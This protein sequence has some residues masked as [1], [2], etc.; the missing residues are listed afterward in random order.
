MADA[1]RLTP[2]SDFSRFVASGVQ[3]DVKNA[4]LKKLFADPHF[5]VMDGLDVYIDDY[6]TPDPLPSGMLRRMAQ[7]KWLGLVTGAMEPENAPPA[8]PSKQDA[9]DVV[10]G[11]LAP[12][13]DR[14]AA[15]EDADLQLQ[16]HDD[17]GR[18]GAAPGAV[19][20]AGRKR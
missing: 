2:G 17:A 9:S 20:D 10:A 16:P 7:A 14:I 6:N 8:G 13:A 11:A 4:A 12:P 19:H 18:A 15:D 3:T 5:N 1:T